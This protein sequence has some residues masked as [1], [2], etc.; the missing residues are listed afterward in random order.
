MKKI[1]IAVFMALIF[2]GVAAQVSVLT[3]HNDIMRM[4]ANLRET[5]LD[6]TNVDTAHFGK[7]C[8]RV[9]DDQVYAQPLVV[10]GVNIPGYGERNVLLI[11]TVN[12]SV[13]AYDAD[14]RLIVNPFWNVNL[15]PGGSR[16]PNVQDFNDLNVCGG[17][18]SDFSGNIGILGTPVIDSTTNTIYLV[19]KNRVNLTGEHQQWLHALDIRNGNEKP[20][21][22]VMIEG[23]MPGNGDGNIGG[24]Q[25][26]NA[27][28]ENQRAALLLSNNIVYITWAGYCDWP[29][30]NG[31]IL[32]Y[33]AQSLQRIVTWSSA[34]N[35][36]AGGIWM[37]GAGI[38]ADEYGNLYACTGNGQVGD[39]GDP[40]DVVNRS[41]SMLKLTR[42]D[43]TL[44]VSSFFTPYNFNYLNQF[45]LDMGTCSIML[46]PGT[47]MAITAGK[48]GYLYVADRDSMGG[49]DTTV[50]HVRQKIDIG[51]VETHS[52]TV[53]WHSDSADY[54]YLWPSYEHPLMRFTVDYANGILDTASKMQSTINDDFKPGGIL[55]LSAN[56]SQNG[57]GI[58]WAN[59][60][61][62]WADA[63]IPDRPGILRAFDA[64][65]ITHELWNSQMNKERDSIKNYPKF[66][67][68]T[69]ANG[70]VYMPTFSGKV[71]M[72]GI[73]NP[74]G[75][76]DVSALPGVDVFPNPFSGYVNVY[77]K[78]KIGKCFISI[79]NSIGDCVYKN[80][81]ESGEVTTI[82]LSS[83]SKGI[84][85][86]SVHAPQGIVTKKV[87][88]TQ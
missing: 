19:T 83:L 60:P 56:G 38:S 44:Q 45:D 73:F 42:V 37:S 14:D 82:D 32:G 74:D 65:N 23:S 24:I 11:A 71:I 77:L 51:G 87:V 18:Y 43:S 27:V 69:I 57:T 5:K 52:G 40:A 49:V 13:Y 85:S 48:E 17:S 88:R 25:Y 20:S 80:T 36:F 39:G 81:F 63:G 8:D 21:S 67:P 34:P 41:Q 29:P 61:L 68:P 33:D 15:T 12:N 35:G 1:S 62:A 75:I 31:W 64:S 50:D 4:G 2:S 84:Y 16:V 54:V 47:D 30:Y 72:Y 3:H 55:S 79:A 10:A 6:I 70:R 46:I 22:P 9:V 59:V 26:F 78:K 7:L 58:I 86:L 28:H 53:F 76:D 66:A